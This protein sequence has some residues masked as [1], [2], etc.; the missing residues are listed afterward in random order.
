M[1]ITQI[2]TTVLFR[3]MSNAET[4]DALNALSAREKSYRKGDVLL[5]AGDTTD[6]MGL[7]L[8]GSVTVESNDIWGNRTILS[9]VEPGGF[10]AET[11]AYLSNEP[12]LVDVT[13]NE[14]CRILF[15]R[16]GSIQT[17]SAKDTASWQKKLIYNLLT[18][19]FHKNLVL[20]GRSFHTAPKTVRGRLMSYL[21]AVSL[22]QGS[23]EFD[24]SFNRQQ[25]ADYLNVERT[26]LSKELGKMQKD[27]ILLTKKNHFKLMTP[28]I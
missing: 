11:Y 25:L 5:L 17:Q 2:Q 12:L 13:A 20:S 15:L 8:E 3:G 4:N 9:L 14:N 1:D 7:V 26:A 16:I 21:N 24:I 19:S 6:E 22:K 18:I 10:F 23:T 28:D 27:G